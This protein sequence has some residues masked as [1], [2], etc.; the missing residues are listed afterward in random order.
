MRIGVYGAGAIGGLLAAYLERGGNE[1]G[2]VARGKQLDAIR[3]EGLTLTHGETHFTTHPVCSDD[4]AEIGACDA[5]IVT[6]KG[7]ALAAIADR[8]SPMLKP[9]TPVIF[10]INGIPWWY[11]HERGAQNSVADSGAAEVLD[12]TGSLRQYV[13]YE[14]AIGCVIDCPTKVAA[15]GKIVCIKNAKGTFTLGEPNGLASDRVS[16][17]AN[18]FEAAGLEAPISDDIRHVIWAKLVVNLSRSPLAV[19]TGSTELRLAEDTAMTEI[20][21]ALMRESI[22]VAAA[23]N[24]AL[25][26]DV[27]GLL[28]PSGRLDHIPSMRQDWDLA[29]PMEVDGIVT[30]VSEFGRAAGIPTPM[31]DTVLTL[32]RHKAVMAGLYP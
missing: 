20:A 15:P 13:G 1:V 28:D 22:A 30:I 17:L 25:D 29:R 18:L 16:K 9:D 24:I 4:P 31:T 2:V 26:L 7:P 19:L 10:A 23:H 6:A 8:I 32:L 14:R 27:P 21:G 11:D 3:A 5:I 12:R